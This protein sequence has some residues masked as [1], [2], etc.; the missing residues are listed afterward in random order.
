MSCFFFASKKPLEELRKK[1]K[2]IVGNEE[3]DKKIGELS[4]FINTGY[5]F[6]NYIDRTFMYAIEIGYTK[7]VVIFIRDRNV[8]PSMRNNDAIREAAKNGHAAVVELLLR[9]GRV[10]PKVIRNTKNPEIQELLRNYD[11]ANKRKI[12]WRLK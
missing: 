2:K 5:H 1:I 10:N 4:N 9:D 7:V 6:Y 8:D 11:K 12:G 3:I